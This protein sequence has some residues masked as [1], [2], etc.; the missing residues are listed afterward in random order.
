MAL[1]LS[2][3]LGVLFVGITRDV[4]VGEASQYTF[5]SN[6][7]LPK[8]MIEAGTREPNGTILTESLAAGGTIYGTV[9]ADSLTAPSRLTVRFWSVIDC[10]ARLAIWF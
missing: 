5:E 10:G 7:V 9:E 1:C 4:Q 8:I 2:A 3:F 6:H